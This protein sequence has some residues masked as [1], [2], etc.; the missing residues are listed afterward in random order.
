MDNEVS[1][2]TR[3][4][5][6]IPQPDLQRQLLAVLHAARGRNEPA[7]LLAP[8]S[9][10]NTRRP[11]HSGGSVKVTWYDPTGLLSRGTGNRF[12]CHVLNEPGMGYL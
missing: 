1:V 10:R 12:S 8:S 4:P 6:V 9:C 2:L 11:F 3:A 5:F 7:L